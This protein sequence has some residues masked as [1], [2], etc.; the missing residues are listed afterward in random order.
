MA[1]ARELRELEQRRMQL[2][3]RRAQLRS[4]IRDLSSR[5]QLAP[6]VERT[7]GM[8]VPNDTQL[9]ILPRSSRSQ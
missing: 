4:Q 6:V 8:H 2:E 9:V 1:N 5:S 7:L 3:A